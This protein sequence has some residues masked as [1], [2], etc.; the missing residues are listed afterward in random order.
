MLSKEAIT[1]YKKLYTKNYGIE[2]TDEEAAR[3]ANNLVALYRIVYSEDS[4]GRI[5]IKQPN[6]TEK[7]TP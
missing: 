5:E 4:F 3:R 1:E 7:T 6:D 2:L